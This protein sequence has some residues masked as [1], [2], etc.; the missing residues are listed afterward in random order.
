MESLLDITTL[1]FLLLLA[2]WIVAFL[3]GE[4]L[5]AGFRQWRT[6]RSER[7]SY[8]KGDEA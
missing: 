1:E 5:N 3:L 2:G 7:T 4:Q 8:S 6:Q